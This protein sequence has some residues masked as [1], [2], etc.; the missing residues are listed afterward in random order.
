[1]RKGAAFVRKVFED[2]A[3]RP[4]DENP[5]KKI[6][7]VDIDKFALCA[8]NRLVYDREISGLL[9]AS[10]FLGLPEYYTP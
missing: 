6:R 7:F 5:V 8:F 10:S 1:M 4:G 3:T 2:V 9:T